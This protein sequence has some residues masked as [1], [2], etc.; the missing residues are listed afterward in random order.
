MN[1]V[2]ASPQKMHTPAIKRE[3]ALTGNAK[4]KRIGFIMAWVVKTTRNHELRPRAAAVFRSCARQQRN[5]DTPLPV[6]FSVF[7]PSSAT[8]RSGVPSAPGLLL[9]HSPALSWKHPEMRSGSW[10]GT[11]STV[12]TA[13]DVLTTVRTS[14]LFRGSPPLDQAFSSPLKGGV[15]P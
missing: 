11:Q 3:T 1:P 12:A 15:H 2:L 5:G 8:A 6:S 10:S 4:R 14:H 13:V 9:S 7:F